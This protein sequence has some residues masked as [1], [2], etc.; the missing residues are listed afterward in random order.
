LLKSKKV[1]SSSSSFK[2]RARTKEDYFA[3]PMKVDVPFLFRSK[4][5]REQLRVAIV[6]NI[7]FSLLYQ[8]LDTKRCLVD[9]A[10]RKVIR[11][12]F[13]LSFFLRLS[14]L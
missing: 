14:S 3:W 6:E 8:S 9:K 10:K 1:F 12:D 4:C 11:R 5:A 13:F 2:T 7:L